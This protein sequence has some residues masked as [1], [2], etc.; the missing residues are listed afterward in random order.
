MQRR[1][2]IRGALPNPPGR[3]I[4]DYQVKSAVWGQVMGQTS[5]V[6]NDLLLDLD[7]L[8]VFACG[9]HRL[10]VNIQGDNFSGP[11]LNGGN[12]KNAGA[13]TQVQHCHPRLDQLLQSL[14][15]G[16]GGWMVAGAKG[17]SRVQF[18]E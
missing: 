6:H 17:Q 3:D 10:R 11:Q 4:G 7:S 9:F 8:D 13:A 2:N 1:Q 18:D 15:T 12:G 5:L 14:Q 16:G